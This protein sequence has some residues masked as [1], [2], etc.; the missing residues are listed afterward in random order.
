MFE[1]KR[2]APEAIPAAL[3][4]AERYRL[5]NQ[6]DAAES[7]CEDVLAIEP[8]NQHALIALLLSLTDQFH[9]G[10]TL[11]FQQSVGL[12]PRLHGEYERAYYAGLIWERRASARLREGGPGSGRVALPW[13]LKAMRYYEQAEEHRPAGNDDAL[14]RWNTCAR[15]THRHHLEPEAVEEYVPALE[16]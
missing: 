10:D 15:L 2:I 8:D 14:L 1:L 11:P 7:I 5:L 3:E 12:L 13:L 4:K 9:D 16:D 6:P